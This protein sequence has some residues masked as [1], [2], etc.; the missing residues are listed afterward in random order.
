MSR[1]Y[2]LGKMAKIYN[3]SP[4]EHI[5]SSQLSE[6]QFDDDEFDNLVA[7][8]PLSQLDPT[9]SKKQ[10]QQNQQSQQ[11]QQSQDSNHSNDSDNLSTTQRLRSYRIVPLHSTPLNEEQ[12]N[13]MDSHENSQNRATSSFYPRERKIVRIIHT[14]K[15][16]HLSCT[17][18]EKRKITKRR[19]KNSHFKFTKESRIKNQ[20]KTK[21]KEDLANQESFESPRISR[22]DNQHLFDAKDLG[23]STSGLGL[24]NSNEFACQKSPACFDIESLNKSGSLCQEVIDSNDEFSDENFEVELASI[25]NSQLLKCYSNKS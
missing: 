24:S 25:T 5:S 3:N 6:Y 11:S 21:P 16:H 14:K 8:M 10:N 2:W 17:H 15:H 18:H 23:L 12:S 1:S 19:L 4:K 9:T 13:H 22:I 7:S 20:F